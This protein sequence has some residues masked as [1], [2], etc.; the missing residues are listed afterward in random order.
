MYMMICW[1]HRFAIFEQDEKGRPTGKPLEFFPTAQVCAKRVRDL[2]DKI[3]AP[4]KGTK[5]GA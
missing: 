3:P 5:K 2:N 1:Q 4:K